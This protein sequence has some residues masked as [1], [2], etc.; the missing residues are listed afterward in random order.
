MW[1]LDP[2]LDRKRT[3]SQLN[4]IH[5][6]LHAYARTADPEIHATHLAVKQLGTPQIHARE[7]NVVIA[8]N[9]KRCRWRP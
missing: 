6:V 9:T 3:R 8:L 5:G 2:R 7:I 1:E 4:R